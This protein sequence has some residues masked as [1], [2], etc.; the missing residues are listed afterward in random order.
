MRVIVVDM[1]IQ[2]ILS[3]T[4]GVSSIGRYKNMEKKILLCVLLIFVTS[5][6]GCTSKEVFVVQ[7]AENQTRNTINS[8]HNEYVIVHEVVLVGYLSNW[9]GDM[10]NSA[11]IKSDSTHIEI[12]F[13]DPNN[14][15]PCNEIKGGDILSVCR[16]MNG[17][18]EIEKVVGNIY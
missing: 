9:Q 11:A 5:L 3:D 4:T 8:A 2:Y 1:F 10:N 16:K 12:L 14:D 15:N 6:S 7:F 18:Y 17:D 13:C